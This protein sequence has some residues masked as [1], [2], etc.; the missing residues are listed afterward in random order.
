MSRSHTVPAF[1]L[2]FG[3]TGLSVARA[4]G[5]HGVRVV[6]LHHEANEPCTMSRYAD[7]HILPP[8]NKGDEPWLRFLLDAGRQLAPVK[9]VL[10]PASDAHWMFIARHRAALEPFFH[11]AMPDHGSPDEWVGKPAQYAAAERAGV[12]YPGT[13][14]IQ[15]P[16]HLLEVSQQAVFPCLIK[17]VLSHLWQRE[18]GSKLAYA[19]T[20]EELRARGGGAMSRGLDIMVQEYIPAPDDEIYCAYSYTDRTGCLLGSCVVRKLRQHE[21]RFGNSSMSECVLQ[22]EVTEL[23]HRLLQELGYRGVSSV[24]FKRD[25]RD[26]RFKLMEL[27]VRATLL[28][29]LAADSGVNLPWLMYR[30]MCGEPP[31]SRPLTPR[32]MG[33]RVGILAND[34]RV[35]RYYR[36]MERN[37]SYLKWMWSW[38]G[39]RDLYFAWDDL[40]PFRGYVHTFIDHVRRGRYRGF[41]PNFPTPEEWAEGRWDGSTIPN[42]SSDNA[43]REAAFP[44]R[45]AS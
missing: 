31:P 15:S 30:D 11:V 21:P 13:F 27:N 4:L 43:P 19:R 44:V 7:V 17:P 34:I 3:S 6:A 14:V 38:V 41:P 20:P 35:A 16:H 10:I 25:P 37:F 1:V 32:R 24:E 23:G 45:H 8:L 36:R 18:Y 9:G 26:G 29:T 33:K 40:G 22:P 39:T 42:D 12:L 28:M 2:W 5:R